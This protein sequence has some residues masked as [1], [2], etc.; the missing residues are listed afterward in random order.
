MIR[1][2]QRWP[3]DIPSERF[4]S[5][6]SVFRFPVQ[7]CVILVIAE[8]KMMQRPTVLPARGGVGTNALQNTPFFA[9]SGRGYLRR[10]QRYHVNICNL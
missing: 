4:E 7:R 9:R 6:F 1:R 10:T 3:S 2:R 5:D 8:P